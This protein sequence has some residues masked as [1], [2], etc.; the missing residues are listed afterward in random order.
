M[1]VSNFFRAA[2]LM[3]TLLLGASAQ[4][5]TILVF[6][7][8]AE[9]PK[10]QSIS[11]RGFFPGPEVE[12]LSPRKGGTVDKTFLFKIKFNPIGGTLINPDS[13]EIKYLSQPAKEISSRVA[14][15]LDGNVLEVPDAV[16][17]P[18]EHVFVVRIKD[19]NGRSSAPTTVTVVNGS[20]H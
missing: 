14:K 17:P 10:A 16:V 2:C 1:G 15:F 4:A 12:V 13:L 5:E 7:H 19:V 20:G 18:G 3:G 9:L 6:P 8:E 11:L